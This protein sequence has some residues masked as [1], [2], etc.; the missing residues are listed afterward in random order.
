MNTAFGLIAPHQAPDAT[1]DHAWLEWL[2]A[3]IDPK[4]RESEWDQS[5]WLFSGDLDNPRTSA[6]PCRTKGC[7]TPAH[8]LDG[9]CYSCGR[10]RAASDLSDE[11]F[12]LL[13]RR[14]LDR[15]MSCAPGARL[16]GRQLVP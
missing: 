1:S 3:H 11:A 10:E 4:W 14:R 6:W 8:R 13:P 9:R 7:P 5:L 2:V 12:D 16:R 15:P